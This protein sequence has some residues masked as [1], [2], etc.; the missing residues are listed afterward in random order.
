MACARS[1]PLAGT[2]SKPASADHRE[3]QIRWLLKRHYLAGATGDAI[4]QVGSIFK[5]ADLGLPDIR[6]TAD[7]FALQ[8]LKMWC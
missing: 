2:W 1:S 8:T 5:A 4:R 3:H 6:D 7:P